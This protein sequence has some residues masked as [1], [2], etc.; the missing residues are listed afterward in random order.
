MTRLALATGVYL[1]VKAGGLLARIC[2]GGSL[3]C[4]P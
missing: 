4:R 2:V 1:I 3:S